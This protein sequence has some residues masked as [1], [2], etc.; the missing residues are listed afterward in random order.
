M[1]FYVDFPL[2]HPAF[3]NS[4]SRGR[5][6]FCTFLPPVSFPQQELNVFNKNTSNSSKRKRGNC[7]TLPINGNELATSSSNSK[8]NPFLPKEKGNKRNEEDEKET[9]F[10]AHLNANTCEKRLKS[11][12]NKEKSPP[13]G[14]VKKH[15][16]P[17]FHHPTY[18]RFND[19]ILDRIFS[20]CSL[21]R[22]GR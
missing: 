18:L 8:T 21:V 1:W 2:L 7:S 16:H 22:R 14:G 20:T 12:K 6:S 15:Q 13:A 17:E 5:S 4:N 9:Q 3:N 11:E 19:H 10:E